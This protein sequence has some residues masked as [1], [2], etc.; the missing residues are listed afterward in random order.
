[1]ERKGLQGV[2]P[3]GFP[4]HL[5]TAGLTTVALSLVPSAVK[6]KIR[7]VF[8]WPGW[9]TVS[10]YKRETEVG[11]HERKHHENSHFQRRHSH[12][13][14]SVGSRTRAHPG[15]WRTDHTCRLV[16]PGGAPCA[17][18]QRVSLRPAW[19]RR[20]WGQRALRSRTRGRRS[21][22]SDHRG[23]WVSLRLWAFLGGRACS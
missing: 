2:T 16:P 18:L 5:D 14:R 15:G 12:C 13:V 23:W 8:C 4:T 1:M 7:E 22:C 9:Y 6:S 3:R 20:E 21:R 17:A 19:P 11:L 10:T